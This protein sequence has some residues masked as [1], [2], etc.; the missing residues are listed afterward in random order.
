MHD[1]L[2]CVD[3]ESHTDKAVEYAL[4]LTRA[5]GAR[6]NALHVVD[7]YLEKFTHEIYAVN[8]NECRAHLDRSLREEGRAALQAFG[9]RAQAAGVDGITELM[10]GDRAE[11]IVARAAACDMVIIGGKVLGNWYRRFESRNLPEQLF[12]RLAVPLLVV[13]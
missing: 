3:G 1:I 6:L 7:P 2:L 8:R 4:S 11:V 5:L 12:R 13:R 10:D 9:K